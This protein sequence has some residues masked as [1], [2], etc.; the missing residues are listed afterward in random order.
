M[1]LCAVEIAPLHAGAEGIAVTAARNRGG[2][3]GQ[4]IAVH[5]VRVVARAYALEQGARPFYA[6]G[7][8]AHVRYR[9]VGPRREARCATRNYPETVRAAFFRCLIQQLHAKADPEHGLLQ[10][11]NHGVQSLPTKSRHRV[12]RGADSGEN[13]MAR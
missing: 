13:D 4:R 11:E 6:Q 7:V 9:P 12:R 1:K 5:E 8:P 3:Q 10:R 2:T